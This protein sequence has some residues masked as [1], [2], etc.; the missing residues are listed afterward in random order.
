MGITMKIEEIKTKYLGDSEFSKIENQINHGKKNW[1]KAIG[2]K[3]AN[4]LTA[5][6]KKIS[7]AEVARKSLGSGVTVHFDMSKKNFVIGIKNEKN[8]MNIMEAKS[9]A[10]NLLKACKIVEQAPN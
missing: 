4:D 10:Q 6:E 3:A 8:S 7:Y 5:N 2:K 1:A 9:L